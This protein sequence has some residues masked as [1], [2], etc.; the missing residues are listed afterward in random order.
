[1]GQVT[2][3]KVTFAF[4]DEGTYG[5]AT[6]VTA[7]ERMYL[8]S[9]GLNGSVARAIDQTLSGYRGQLQSI[10]GDTTVGGS[11]PVVVAPESI[12]RWLKHLIGAPTVYAPVT[13][14]SAV[15][16][17]EVLRASAASATGAGTLTY[18]HSGT[19]LAWAENGDTAGTAVNISAGGRFTITST[20]GESVYVNV[21]PGSLPGTDDTATVTVVTGAYEHV[22]TVGNLPTGFLVEANLGTDIA[23]AYRWIR[24]LGC[25]IAQGQFTFSPSGFIEA[26]FDVRGASFSNAAGATLDAT[27]DDYG[28][29]AFSM[30]NA[31][32]KE[33]GAAIATCT[34]VQLTYNNDLDDSNRVIGGGGILGSMPEGFANISGNA[35]FLFSTAD[36]LNKAIAGTETSLE[37]AVTKGTGAG[38]DGNEQLVMRI[39][40]LLFEATTPNVEGPRGLRLP[41]NFTTHRGTGAEHGFE[42]SLR[43]TRS[44]I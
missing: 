31:T 7:T 38:T 28:H 29:S 43:N 30:F 8:V 6:G 10:Q 27:P 14:A 33:A 18:T 3:R 36:Q 15:P 11:I 42:V 32:I 20:S 41:L 1:M 19:T 25:R 35:T 17:V 9:S 26:S 5:S 24:Y 37:I 2:G 44:T 23:E 34:N 22:F 40:R 4:A 21:T 39:P 13:V 12:G 16:G